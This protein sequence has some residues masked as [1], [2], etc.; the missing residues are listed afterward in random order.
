MDEV[1]DTKLHFSH[2]SVSLNPEQYK[3]VIADPHEHRR[4][5]AAAGSGKTTTITSRISWLL[6]NTRVSA[7]QIVLL[8]FCRNPEANEV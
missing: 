5:L 1:E 6:T 3:I 8:T 4:I 7:D 2:G